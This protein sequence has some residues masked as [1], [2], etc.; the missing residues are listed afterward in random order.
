MF[1]MTSR[2]KKLL[3]NGLFVAGIIIAVIG[4][5]LTGAAGDALLVVAFGLLAIGVLAALAGIVIGFIPAR[6]A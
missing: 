1:P 6:R 4:V 2:Q 5:L 3:S